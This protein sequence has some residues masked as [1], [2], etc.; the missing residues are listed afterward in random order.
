MTV[1]AIGSVKGAPGVTTTV[2]A[3]AAVWPA[4]R[5]VVVA[6]VDPDGGVLAAR[7]ELCVEPG[8]VTLAT[9]LRRGGSALPTHTQALGANVRVLVTPPSAEQTRAALNV[10]GE[11]LWQAFDALTDDLLV[12]CGRLTVTSP[13]I[14][15]ARRAAT[16]LLMARPRLEDIALLRERVPALRREGVAPRL[17]LAGDGPYGHD[18]IA[19]A[20][21]A[22]VTAVLPADRRTAEAL[23]TR[24]ARGLSSRAPLLRSA[25]HLGALLL[26]G[27]RAAEAAP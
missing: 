14:A 1:I 8:L 6:E 21:A 23:D 22:P 7:R 11:R 12:D 5:D 15:A 17:L 2:M 19:T 27:Q 24:S 4:S 9:A 20:V 18:E 10:A 25:R 16:T 13:A 26:A 3:L